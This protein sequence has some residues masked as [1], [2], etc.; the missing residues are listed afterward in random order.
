MWT[1]VVQKDGKVDGTKV[2]NSKSVW[3]KLSDLLL[4]FMSSSN[5]VGALV[6]SLLAPGLPQYG[7][8]PTPLSNYTS[9]VDSHDAKQIGKSILKQLHAEFTLPIDLVT[10]LF[11]FACPNM[12][13]QGNTADIFVAVFKRLCFELDRVKKVNDEAGLLIKCCERCLYVLQ[14]MLICEPKTAM[15]IID[16][17]GE[18]LHEVIGRLVFLPVLPL[19]L[20]EIGKSKSLSR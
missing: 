7:T 13:Y 14:E 15:H 17:I 6:V 20:D 9:A 3:T 18:G 16:V 12:D 8:D 19:G 10:T 4:R 5:E 2:P 11:A 1:G